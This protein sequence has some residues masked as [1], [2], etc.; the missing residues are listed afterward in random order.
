MFAARRNDRVIGR[1]VTLLV[2][3]STRNGFSQS[4]APSGRR[5][6]IDFIIDFENLDI[7]IVSQS[8][9]PKI[10]VKIKWLDVLKKYGI[11]P[12]RLITIIERNRVV[13]IC[14][15]PLRLFMNVRDSCAV[16]I[17]INGDN[18]EF[19]REVDVQKVN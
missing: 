5:C 4:G 8:G 2:S 15:N 3:I 10:N 7:I 11:N 13:V 16:M 19:E 9:K 17:R 14:L 18:M 6:A 12:N 1:T